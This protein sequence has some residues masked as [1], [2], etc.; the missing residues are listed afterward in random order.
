MPLPEIGEYTPDFTLAQHENGATQHLAEITAQAPSLIAFFKQSC[1]T[2]RLTLPF[3]ERLHR[4]YPALQV[5]GISQDDAE[6]T[7]AFVQQTG[8][9]FPV[10]RDGDWK[11]S[12]AYDLFTVPSVFLLDKGGSVRRVNM[13]WNKEQYLGLSDEI[14]RVLDTA[15]VPLLTDSDK[16]PIFKPG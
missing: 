2:C 11:V 12:T 9:T 15:P 14:A 1:V 8:L 10:V 4:H 16:V 13:G 3:I 6:D 7:S 5:L